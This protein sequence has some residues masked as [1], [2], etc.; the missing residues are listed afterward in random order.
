MKRLER[1]RAPKPMAFWPLL[2]CLS[3]D[4][5]FTECSLYGYIQAIVSPRLHFPSDIL[6]VL[7]ALPPLCSFNWRSV[8]PVSWH[9]PSFPIT[10]SHLHVLSYQ[11]PSQVHSICT[12]TF[13]SHWLVLYT[14]RKWIVLKRNS[15]HT[16]SL[17]QSCYL[18]NTSKWHQRHC[19]TT[20]DWLVY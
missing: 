6:F 15:R 5:C 9:F 19:T 13:F 7:S 20:S 4:L 8:S 12:C 2:L 17:P 11:C 14:S 16:K 10:C 18:M 1:R 3:S